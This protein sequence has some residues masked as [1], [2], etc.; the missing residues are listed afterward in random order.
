[1]QYWRGRP[2][3]RLGDIDHILWW[4]WWFIYLWDLNIESK[5]VLL[6][7]IYCWEFLVR[8]ELLIV[9]KAKKLA[10]WVVKV[11]WIFRLLETKRVRHLIWCKLFCAIHFLGFIHNSLPCLEKDILLI[12]LIFGRPLHSL[13]IILPFCGFGSNKLCWADLGIARSILQCNLLLIKLCNHGWFSQLR[14]F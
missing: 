9:I 10:L 11:S 7:L 1:M 8:H 5:W 6:L 2:H 13:V 3:V 12:H 14:T 4:R